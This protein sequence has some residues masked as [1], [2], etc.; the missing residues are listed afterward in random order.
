MRRRAFIG[1][2]DGAAAAWALA[3]GTEES[4]RLIGV[5][6]LFVEAIRTAR[7]AP[8]HSSRSLARRGWTIGRN[9]RIDYRWGIDITEKAQS[10]TNHHGARSRSAPF[11]A[12]DRRQ[13][14]R[15]RKERGSSAV[16]VAM[17]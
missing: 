13:S 9:V 15:M 17:P 1:L 10:S 4:V 7:P 3:P 16:G 12:C 6:M 11:A 5:L 2:L 8:W 14:D